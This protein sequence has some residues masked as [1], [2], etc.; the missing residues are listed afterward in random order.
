LNQEVKRL[1][2]FGYL[3]AFL[4]AGMFGMVSTI[5]KPI[6][7]SVDPLLLASLVY[8]VSAATLTPIAQKSK[9][10]FPKIKCWGIDKEEAFDYKRKL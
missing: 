10:Q 3:F 8:L 7:S 4:A 1:A 5:A 6:V 9:F 2:R